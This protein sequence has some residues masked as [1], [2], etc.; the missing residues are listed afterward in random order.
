MADKPYKSGNSSGGHGGSGHHQNTWQNNK[1]SEVDADEVVKK[2]FGNDFVDL[3]LLQK[4][5]SYN[6]YIDK[7]KRYVE[8]T[9][10]GM[11]TSQL[12]NVYSRIKN[13]ESI[14]ELFTLRPKVAYVA[15]RADRHELKTFLYLIDQLIRSVDDVSKLKQLKD[16]FEAIIAYHKYYGGDK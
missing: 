10:K 3:I 1:W 11:T 4:V 15:G 2:Y 12:R 5:S 13:L 9:K 16:F 7:V 14:T 8:N 6:E